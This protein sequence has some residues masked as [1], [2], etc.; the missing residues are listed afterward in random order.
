VLDQRAETYSGGMKRR[1]NLAIALL[2]AP[3]I[4]YLDEPTV[5]IDAR[6]RQ[7]IVDVIGALK[8]QGVTIVYTSHYM[9]EVE[10]L[11]DML[12]VI[13]RGR[14]VESG[15]KEDVLRRHAARALHVALETPLPEAAR[16]SL[17]AQGARWRD[18]LRLDMP[19]ADT[20]D[21]AGCLERIA[22]AGGKVAH[23]QFGIARLEQMYLSLTES[24]AAT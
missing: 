2:S 10:A 16:A 20:S 5:G 6:S 4:L 13:D 18:D 12:A 3:Q 24:N 17:T 9:E 21:V 15:G 19:A 7:T 8:A 23:L 22:Q 11:C 1:L 14:M